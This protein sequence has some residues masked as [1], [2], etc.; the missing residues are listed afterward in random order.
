MARYNLIDFTNITFGDF[1]CSLPEETLNIIT[2][3]AQQ[4]GS[5]TY[6]RTPVFTKRDSGLLRNNTMGSATNQVDS[7]TKKKRRN[8]RPVEVMNDTDWNTVRSFQA[9][10]IEQKKGLDAQIDIIRCYLNKMT[11]KNFTDLCEQIYTVLDVILESE[12]CDDD[13]MRIGNA[14]FEIASNNRFYSKLYADLYANLIRKYEI[15]NTIFETTLAGFLTIFDNIERVVSEEDYDKFCKINM[16]NERRKALSSFFVNLTANKIITEDKLID[17]T[18]NLIMK[19][20]DYLNKE[21]MKS[22]VD[23][24]MENI[25]ILYSKELFV[26][27]KNNIHDDKTFIQVIEMLARSKAKTFA[28]LSNKTI[29][30]CMDM[31]EM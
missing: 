6:I 26:R 21:G 23:E 25:A 19:V 30:K 28:S 8:N 29:F 1:E 4:V 27:Y 5:P 22:E 7:F 14:I 24:I 2:E 11:E 16:D 13:M 9:T 17:L 12:S 15:M 31:V 18:I 3:L 10:K 20:L